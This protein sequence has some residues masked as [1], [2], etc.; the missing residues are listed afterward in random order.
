LLD[1]LYGARARATAVVHRD[2]RLLVVR[3]KG[4]RHFSLPGG[5]VRRGERPEDAAVRE[6]REETGLHAVS[7]SPLPQCRTSDIFN[8]YHVFRIEAGGEVRIDP[9]ELGEAMWWDGRESLPLFAYVK[10]V[11]RQLKWPNHD[12]SGILAP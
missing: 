10:Y 7:I 12:T 8:T 2:G 4:F 5:G 3:D 6:L 11:L 1:R 9:V